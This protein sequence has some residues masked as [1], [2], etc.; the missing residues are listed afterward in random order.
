MVNLFRDQ[1]KL[2]SL[3]FCVSQSNMGL[4][5]KLIPIGLFFFVLYNITDI[6][7]PVKIS[8]YAP[9]IVNFEPQKH[10]HVVNDERICTL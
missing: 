8:L 1:T 6:G 9:G 5:D 2:L 3:S 7:S 10:V 4:V